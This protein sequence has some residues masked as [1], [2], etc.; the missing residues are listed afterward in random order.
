[1]LEGDYES[2]DQFA[3][4]L[5]ADLKTWKAFQISPWLNNDA[6]SKL[7]HEHTKEFTKNTH[8]VCSKLKTLRDSSECDNLCIALYPYEKIHCFLLFVM[9]DNHETENAFLGSNLFTT[10]TEQHVIGERMIEEFEKLSQILYGVGIKTCLTN[11]VPG[12]HE[13]LYSHA[14]IWYFINY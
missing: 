12:D 8:V 4:F 2:I 9:I 14:M 10:E 3:S 13:T 11:L 1:M 7:K 6:S 5:L